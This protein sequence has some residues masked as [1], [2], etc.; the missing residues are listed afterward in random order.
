MTRT[1]AIDLL[2]LLSA[3]ESWALCN[4]A[5]LPDYLH[6]RMV[7]QIEKLRDMAINGSDK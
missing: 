6:D 5:P 7:A 2:T 3:L 4:T 1:D